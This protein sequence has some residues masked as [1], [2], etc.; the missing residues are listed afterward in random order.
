VRD[1][2]V[3]PTLAALLG[4]PLDPVDGV[5]LRPLL[6][7]AR[8][9]LGLTAY[10]ETGLWLVGSG[11]GFPPAERLPY[12]ALPALITIAAGDDIV[13]DPQLADL[14]VVAKHRALTTE[15]WKLEYAPTRAGV[16]FAL[17]DRAADPGELQ[18]VAAAHPAELAALKADLYRWMEEDGS[19]V[20]AGFVVPR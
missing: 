7:G 16:R 20:E 10:H 13:L 12:P 1:V 15:R 6:D 4:V 17:Y 5:D 11:P 3:A 18:D 8:P 9:S 2:D 19:T 14:V